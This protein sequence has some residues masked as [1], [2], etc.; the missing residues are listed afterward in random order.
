MT[1]ETTQFQQSNR[2]RALRPVFGA[3]A[4]M[5]A[6]AT[7]GLAVAGPA[8]LSRSAPAA[9]VSVMASR[10]DARATEVAILPATI[11]VVG[12]RTKAAGSASPF[13]PATFRPRG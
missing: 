5:A 2:D 13:V 8:A 12:K 6:M 9:E 7:M 10:G 11:Q 4:V 3:V 1:Y